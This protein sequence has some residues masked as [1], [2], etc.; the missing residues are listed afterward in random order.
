MRSQTDE[1]NLTDY[2]VGELGGIEREAVEARLAESETDR[3]SVDEVRWAAGMIS[4]E[5][6]RE[7]SEGLDA[8]HHAALE[9]RLR[10]LSGQR[11]V[12]RRDQV[13]GRIGFAMS[14]AASIAIIGGAVGIILLSISRQTHIAINVPVTQPSGTPI[15]IPLGTNSVASGE[16]PQGL[17]RV[18]ENAGRF[19]NAAD[20]PVSTFAFNTDPRTYDEVR[21]AIDQGR[22]PTRD[23]LKIDGLVNAFAYD[24]P[25]PASGATFGGSIE[26]G[27]CPWQP[28][29]Q[30]ARIAVMAR[31]GVGTVAQDVRTEVAFAPDAVRSYRLLGYD[32]RTGGSAHAAESVQG[33]RSV[34]ALY[35]IVPAAIA[36]AKPVEPLTLR[37]RYRLPDADAEQSVQFHPSDARAPRMAESVDF[38]F[39]AAVAEFGM[40]LRGSPE[41]GHA[42]MDEVVALAES[43]RGSDRLGQREQFIDL[44]RHA[45]QLMG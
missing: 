43:G 28:A 17:A 32:E 41:R 38:R 11:P 16:S 34:T 23:S 21:Q 5:L 31:Q 12:E 3:R 40:L 8:I 22:R 1:K 25:A 30:L 14:L 20:H 44:A 9:L 15:L 33:G 2:A 26:V 39:A 13:G 10:E 27:Q 6:A 42:T 24:D 7:P 19:V 35:E 36:P 45:K 18:G 29:H 4:V 37:V